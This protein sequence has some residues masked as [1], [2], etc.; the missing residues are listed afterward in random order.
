MQ[1]SPNSFPQ[2]HKLKCTLLPNSEWCLASKSEPGH[3]H[4]LLKT[5]KYPLSTPVVFRNG[6]QKALRFTGNDS[7]SMWWWQGLVGKFKWAEIV[8]FLPFTALLLC[9]YLLNQNRSTFIFLYIVVPHR[10]LFG[11]KWWR[12]WKEGRRL[13]ALW[14]VKATSQHVIQD[15]QSCL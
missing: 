4:L 2:T 13:T 7:G 1:R 10:I 15:R 5:V 8:Q 3:T 12:R 11:A 14:S 9:P 6:S